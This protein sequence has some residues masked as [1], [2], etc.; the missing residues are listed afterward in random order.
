MSEEKNCANMLRRSPLQVADAHLEVS[1]L[2]P[3]TK[4]TL[5]N[6]A[7]GCPAQNNSD[8][9]KSRLSLEYILYASLLVGAI[10]SGF[11]IVSEASRVH[12]GRHYVQ[13]PR[14][15]WLSTPPFNS[16]GYNGLGD[17]QWKALD[18]WFWLL[19]ALYTCFA[20]GSRVIR[21]AFFA[22]IG[23]RALHIYQ[24][25]LGVCF[26]AF[27]HGP[28]FCVPLTLAL[29]N[30]GFVVFFVGSGVS[31]RVFMAVMWLS[32][33]TLLFLVRFCGEK[34]MSVFQSASDSMWSR[35]LRWTVVFNMYTL[36]MVAF[37]MD[38]Y[39]AFRDGPTQ[40]ERAVRKHDTNCLECAQMRE[41]N[42]D[43][44]SP[45]TRCYRFRTESSCH[46]REYNLLS[47]IAYMLYIPLYV[48]GPMSSFNAFASHCHCTTV[49]MPRR[50]MVL[51][52]LRV[53]TL[54][55]TLIFMLHFTFVNA[56][57][58]RPEVFWELSVFESSSLL[59]YCLAFL[60]L[61]FSL[62][63]KL[64]RLAAV[65]DGFDVPEDMRRCFTNT[66]SVQDFWRD[67]HASLNLWIVRYMY[68]PMGGN[69]MKHFNIFPIFFF[70]AIWHDVELHLVKWAVCAY[71]L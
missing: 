17:A 57:R 46:P 55:L 40:R 15:K 71:F 28:E 69:R 62:V 12:I 6:E 3:L 14:W 70:I 36:R 34:M 10:F 26:V 51:Y 61:K 38:M 66:V 48:A 8:L 16:V 35:K 33:L 11:I 7:N 19:I 9:V 39:E 47:Y 49:A 18:R 31:Y 13:P 32:Q 37:N 25:I 60:W 5:E 45:T 22:R 29:M 64:S 59:Y 58:M 1:T 68:I 20:M 63:W 41:A 43:E 23:V 42:R 54:Y 4:E 21:W 56:F 44:N 2:V 65:S 67:W 30:Y 53:L 50:Q 24:S 52:A 27:L